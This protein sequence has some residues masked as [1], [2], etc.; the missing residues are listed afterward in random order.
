MRKVF[1][2]AV[3]G[4]VHGMLYPYDF[5]TLSPLQARWRGCRLMLKT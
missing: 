3:T 2:I 4:D 1:K 5:T